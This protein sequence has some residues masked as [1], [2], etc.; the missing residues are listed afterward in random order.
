[1][2]RLGLHPILEHTMTT[3]PS[4]LQLGNGNK[5]I[6]IGR[7]IELVESFVLLLPLVLVINVLPQKLCDAQY[8]N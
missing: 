5:I 3:H 8:V 1:M 4:V 6:I 2:N 7:T